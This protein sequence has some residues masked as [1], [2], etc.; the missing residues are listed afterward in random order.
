MLV[1]VVVDL[2]EEVKD[3]VVLVEEGLEEVV[4]EPLILAEAAALVEVVL[5]VQVDLVLSLFDI[6]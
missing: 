3:L 2:M 4:L 5:V 1:V 6:K